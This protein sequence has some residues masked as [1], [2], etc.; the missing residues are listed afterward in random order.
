M[1][2]STAL[3]PRRCVAPLTSSRQPGCS[4][5]RVSSRRSVLATAPSKIVRRNNSRAARRGSACSRHSARRAVRYASHLG[6]Q[7][8][9]RHGYSVAGGSAS[10]RHARPVGADPHGAR[11]SRPPPARDARTR[12]PSCALSLPPEPP[13]PEFC[14]GGVWEL[15]KV[16][17][18][19]ARA[20]SSAV[21]HRHQRVDQ[22]HL[23][24]QQ[25]RPS[26]RRPA[27]VGASD[28]WVS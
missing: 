15:R 23:P 8:E 14:K 21:I 6:E 7:A 10:A 19:F 4:C 13:M 25:G 16:L 24:I 28:S 9:C 12:L 1:I 11:S 27:C 5:G 22:D 17:R 3:G 2:C 18:G 26:R 20:A